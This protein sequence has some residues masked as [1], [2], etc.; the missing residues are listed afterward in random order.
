MDTL[1]LQLIATDIREVLTE[2]KWR[3]L[4]KARKGL[5]QPKAVRCQDEET[6]DVTRDSSV[7]FWSF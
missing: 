1:I 6:R 3:T 4:P 2:E 7:Y 5:G